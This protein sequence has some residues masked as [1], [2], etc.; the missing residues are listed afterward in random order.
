MASEV[1]D[2]DCIVVF[3]QSGSFSIHHSARKTTAPIVKCLKTALKH[4][5]VAVMF[6][7]TCWFVDR[8]GQVGLK[9]GPEDPNLAGERGALLS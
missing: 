6:I 1:S 3:D 2:G 8:P 5:L 9:E 7:A 4:V